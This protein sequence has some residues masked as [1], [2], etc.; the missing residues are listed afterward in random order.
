VTAAAEVVAILVGQP[1]YFPA[2]G[3][4]EV[5]DRRWS[6]AYDKRPATGP[7]RLRRTGLDG[8]AQADPVRHGGPDRAVL[9]YAAEHYSR[10]RNELGMPAIPYGSFGE[11]LVIAGH[12]EGSICI[13][14]IYELGEAV[15]QVSMPRRPCNK[16]VWRWRRLDMVEL[17]RATGR[18][19]WFLRVL[20]EGMVATGQLLRLVD[21]PHPRIDVRRAGQVLRRPHDDRAFAAE[22]AG[23]A[24]LAGTLRQALLRQLAGP[25]TPRSSRPA[26]GA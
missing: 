17:V 11:N 4:G 8:D 12:D 10:W 22:L 25:C 14:D 9:G 21:R 15:L 16:I 18:H 24:A 5:W 13:G 7:V 3:D 20:A 6:S 19:G 1:R 2:S 23:C 26:A